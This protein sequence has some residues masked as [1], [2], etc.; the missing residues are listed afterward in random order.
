MVRSPFPWYFPKYP[1]PC[2]QPSQ[3]PAGH[4]PHYKGFERHFHQKIVNLFALL[5]NMRTI[6]SNNRPPIGVSAQQFLHHNRPHLLIGEG[7]VIGHHHIE[8]QLQLVASLHVKVMNGGGTVQFPGHPFDQQPQ[9]VHLRI[10]N[11]DWIHMDHRLHM[12]VAG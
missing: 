2:Q 10:P 1:F 11:L 4:R 12:K 3:P 5:Q 7:H 9:L 6:Y 8:A